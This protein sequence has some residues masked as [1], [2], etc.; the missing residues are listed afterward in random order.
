VW[1]AVGRLSITSRGEL[2]QDVGMLTMVLD[3][4]EVCGPALR[5]RSVGAV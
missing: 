2:A 5:D 3:E 1:R 4:S